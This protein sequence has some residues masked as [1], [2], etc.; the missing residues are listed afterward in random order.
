MSI[1]SKARSGVEFYTKGRRGGNAI[2]AILLLF[3]V[4]I[5]LI[6]VRQ[7]RL[8]GMDQ[9]PALAL[10]AILVVV[11]G[12]FAPQAVTLL[13]GATLVAGVLDAVQPVS[14]A[15]AAVNRQFATLTNRTPPF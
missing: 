6:S 2:P 9:A 5:A 11:A 14:N 15:L 7:G 13:L 8:V 4:L 10:G 12:L 3:L 1:T